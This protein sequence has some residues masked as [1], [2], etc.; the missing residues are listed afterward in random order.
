MDPP[1]KGIDSENLTELADVAVL[2]EDGDVEE[3]NTEYGGVV[4]MV[5]SAFRRSKD[6]RL[7][8]ETAGCLHIAIIAVYTARM[9]NLPRQKSQKPLLK[10]QKR[11][12]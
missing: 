8:D 7:T 3:E 11:R 5:E 12:F 9:Y 6:R 4:A 2:E 10:S 1:K